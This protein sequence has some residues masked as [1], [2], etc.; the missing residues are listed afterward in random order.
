MEGIVYL[1]PLYRLV[2]TR[3]LESTEVNEM[4]DISEE[5]F[6]VVLESIAATAAPELVGYD[7]A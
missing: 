3:A 7:L 1:E 6:F 2:E 5:V 4:V